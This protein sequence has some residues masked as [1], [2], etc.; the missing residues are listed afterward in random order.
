MPYFFTR[1]DVQ[2]QN[3]YMLFILNVAMVNSRHNLITLKYNQHS[4]VLKTILIKKILPMHFLTTSLEL[5]QIMS[6]TELLI[7][8]SFEVNT[9]YA[10]PTERS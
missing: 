8:I 10:G 4:I 6:F 3:N 2:I 9:V 5:S 1:Y 7:R